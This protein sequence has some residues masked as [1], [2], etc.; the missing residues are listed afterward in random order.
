[1]GNAIKYIVRCK[2]K[3][4]GENKIEDLRKAIWYLNRQIALWERQESKNG[5]DK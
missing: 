3:F 1:L 4:N 5:E 2:K